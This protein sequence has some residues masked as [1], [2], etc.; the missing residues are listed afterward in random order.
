MNGMNAYEARENMPIGGAAARQNAYE[1][2]DNMPI[3]GVKSGNQMFSEAE[4]DENAKDKEEGTENNLNQKR[5]FL[6]K[7]AK[8]DPRKAIEDAKKKQN[9]ELVYILSSSL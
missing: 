5:Q 1:E 6:K 4:E 7:K 8:Y 9:E 3:R 2:R